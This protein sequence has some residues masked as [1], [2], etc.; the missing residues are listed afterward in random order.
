MALEDKIKSLAD[1]TGEEVKKLKKIAKC[2]SSDVDYGDYTGKKVVNFAEDATVPTSNAL[3]Y[4]W[5]AAGYLADWDNIAVDSAAVSALEGLIPAL[6]GGTVVLATYSS[7][8]VVRLWVDSSGHVCYVSPDTLRWVTMIGGIMHTESPTATN[9]PPGTIIPYVGADVPD[10][11]LLCNGALISRT[12]Y[13][14]LFGAIG[15]TFGTGDGSTTF[16]IPNMTDRFLEGSTSIAYVSAGAPNVTGY[17]QNLLWD[18]G[19]NYNRSGALYLTA[20]NRQRTWGSS[21]GDAMRTLWVNAAWSNSL[22][23]ASSTI[24]PAALKCL[25]I[26]KY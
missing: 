17:V 6:Q 20:G 19:A 25:M 2:I 16:A 21:G 18:D 14:D 12:A 4:N 22:Y 15:T 10:G 9:L 11:Y 8:V 7:N 13:A 23:G 5:N 26:I 3:V 24:Q 1:K